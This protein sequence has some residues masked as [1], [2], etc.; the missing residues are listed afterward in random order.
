M[1]ELKQINTRLTLCGDT[2]ANWQASTK[3]LLKNEVA[4]EQTNTV[5]KIKI[6]DGIHTFS[7]L[8]YTTMTPAEIQ[9]LI[10]A[11][12]HTHANKAILDAIEVALTNALKT[13]Y[14]AAYTHSTTA[15]AP[16]NAEANVQSDWN[17]TDTSSD[18]YIKNKPTIPSVPE[19]SVAE[20][21]TSSGYAKSYQLT[22]NGTGIGTVINVPKDMV[23]SGGSVKTVT[24]ANSPYDGAVIGDKYMDLVI[25]N[26][27]SNHIYIPVKDLVD[28]YT[29][30]TGITISST[31]VV[32]INADSSLSDTSTNAV[33]NK[34]VKTALDG[35]EPTI[36][37]KNTA[38]NKNF[39]TS[40]SAYKAPGTAS[41][42]T[43]TNVA[44]ADHVH[45]AQTSVSGNAGTATKLQNAR[46]IALQ[47]G[48]K[49]TAT[50]F[51]GSASISIGVTEINTDYLTL[52]AKTLIFNGGSASI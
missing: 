14:D 45:P 41:A 25:A 47:D 43:S 12:N 50:S 4:I 17:V 34:I 46:T 13:T 3:V 8:P 38:F 2:S 29:S 19:Y 1:S 49:G 28:T 32:S 35:K 20:V 23:I 15:H 51:D 39:E 18:A 52:G 24:T 11:S 26:A 44:K 42:G 36:G 16:S 10:G 30:G 40:V 33:Q 48:A 9:A 6:G 5:P 37:T 31:N 21:S 27:A 7:E 22:K